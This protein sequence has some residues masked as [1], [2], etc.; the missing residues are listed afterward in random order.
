MLINVSLAVVQAKSFCSLYLIVISL[1]PPPKSVHKKYYVLWSYIQLIPCQ[2][3]VLLSSCNIRG[4]QFILFIEITTFSSYKTIPN[5]QV[6]AKKTVCITSKLLLFSIFFF[7]LNV[8][9]LGGMGGHLKLSSFGPWQT[10]CAMHF[11]CF[12]L[13]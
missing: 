8:A 13:H 2:S 5:L 9:Y 10:F 1:C 7:G 4:P 11:T 3:E 12:G 6:K